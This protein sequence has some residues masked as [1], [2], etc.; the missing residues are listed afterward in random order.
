MRAWVK[1]NKL[2][3]F[4]SLLTYDLNDFITSGILCYSYYK[5]KLDSEVDLMPL[6]LS[7]MQLGLEL[8]NLTTSS[9]QSKTLTGHTLYMVMSMRSFLMT[10]QNHLVRL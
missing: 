3:D 2:E 5:D 9:Y 4:T 7:I 8:T 6:G 1:H 10:C